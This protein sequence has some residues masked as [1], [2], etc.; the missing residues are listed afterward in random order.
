MVLLG[1]A[2][3]ATHKTRGE[4]TELVIRSKT[5]VR[6]VKLRLIGI[7]VLK[8]ESFFELSEIIGNGTQEVPKLVD[9][10]NGTWRGKGV[11]IGLNDDA[12]SW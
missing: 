5:P 11:L 1:S 9:H 2:T 6:W 10:F 3:L 4:V 12:G 8:P 7:Q